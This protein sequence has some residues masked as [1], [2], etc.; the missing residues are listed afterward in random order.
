[1]IYDDLR[2]TLSN[3]RSGI[4]FL[5]LVFRDPHRYWK[6]RSRDRGPPPTSAGICVKKW[7]SMNRKKNTWQGTGKFRVLSSPAR[8][9]RARKCTYPKSATQVS[10]TDLIQGHLK[11]CQVD[12]VLKDN[13]VMFYQNIDILAS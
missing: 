9:A 5:Y 10:S 7:F 6:F 13:I 4:F 8:W 11:G 2:W 1:M 12:L 3:S